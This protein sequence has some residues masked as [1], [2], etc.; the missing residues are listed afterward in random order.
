M[1]ALNITK[2]FHLATSLTNLDLLSSYSF[3]ELI[4]EMLT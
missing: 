2:D 1:I 4:M 3:K